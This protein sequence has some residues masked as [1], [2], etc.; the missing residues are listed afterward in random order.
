MWKFIFKR[1]IALIPVI[2]GVTLI[3]F[4]IM[5]LSPGD[6]AKMILGDEASPEAVQLLRQEMGL[7]D[8]LLVQYGRYMYNAIQGDMGL[9]YKSKKPVTEEIWARF[10]NT[11]KLTLTAITFAVIIS[12]PLGILAAVK[13]NSFFDGFSMLLALFGVSMPAFWFGLLL[14]L[15]FSLKLGWFPSSGSESLKSIVFPSIALGFLHMAAIARTTRSSML[16]VI[17]Q[18]YIRTAR[19]KGLSYGAVIRKHALKNA[20]IPTITVVGLQVGVLLGGAVIVETV[21]AWPGVGRLMV[22]SIMGRDIPMVM[23]CIILFATGFTI[24]NLIVDLLYGFI[25]P[26]IRSMYA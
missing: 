1:V 15:F 14:I 21:F 18:D 26:R 16:E 24:V 3:V 23:G 4:F 22:Q 10:P 7:D 17:R 20:L 2:I 5:S 19:S 8:P 25:D 6:P 9:S 11:I 12:L 13:Q